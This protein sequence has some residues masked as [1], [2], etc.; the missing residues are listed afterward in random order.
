MKDKNKKDN[1]SVKRYANIVLYSVQARGLIINDSIYLEKLT[2]E[3][4]ARYF[5]PSKAKRTHLFEFILGNERITAMSKKDVLK[6]IIEANYPDIVVANK[7]LFADLTTII[8]ERNMFAHQMVDASKEAE[9]LEANSFHLIRF[10][11]STRHF[12]YNETKVISHLKMI[13]K[14]IDVF[15][16]LLIEKRFNPRNK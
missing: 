7:T 2:D 1:D 6:L 11:N 12:L 8:E 14:Y 9:K 4:I 16:N 5:C 10:K 15:Q 13:G 3:F